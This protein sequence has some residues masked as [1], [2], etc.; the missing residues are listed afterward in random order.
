MVRIV[1]L[2]FYVNKRDVV[3]LLPNTNVANTNKYSLHLATYAIVVAV[4]VI[5]DFTID[6]VLFF[7][8]NKTYVNF[9][10]LDV[11]WLK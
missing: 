4:T 7:G 5:A 6:I 8:E 2:Y 11:L 10:V 1:K 9:L 3:Q